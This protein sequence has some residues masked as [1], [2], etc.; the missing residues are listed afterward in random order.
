MERENTKNY[1]NFLH[2]QG[3]KEGEIKSYKNK[4]I[5]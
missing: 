2:F 5:S 4:R 3:E 1:V